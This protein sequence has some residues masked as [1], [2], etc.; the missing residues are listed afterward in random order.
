MST[1]ERWI[2]KLRNSY[3]WDSGNLADEHKQCEFCK[4]Y[5][6]VSGDLGMD[7]GVCINEE[8]PHDMQVVFEHFGCGF[9]EL[10]TGG[11]IKEC[12]Q[13]LAF[14]GLEDNYCRY[15]GHR[16]SWVLGR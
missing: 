2:T 8:S 3:K 4:F 9:N 5:V 13:C 11:A 7:W 16:F 1:H 10:S 14:A 15:C 12:S 6:E